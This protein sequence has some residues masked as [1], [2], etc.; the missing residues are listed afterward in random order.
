MLSATLFIWRY[1]ISIHNHY[2]NGSLTWVHNL[3]NIV[4]QRQG[5][6]SISVRM[7]VIVEVIW[8]LFGGNMC[9][10]LHRR[11]CF[12]SAKDIHKT[13]PI[14]STS[15][16]TNVLLLHIRKRYTNLIFKRTVHPQITVVGE[17]TRGWI[18]D[19][20]SCHLTQKQILLGSK[21]HT[22]A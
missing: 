3:G 13:N 19:S 11:I 1:Y 12:S 8:L 17:L 5:Q 21:Q 2:H 9:L 14:L 20:P 16:Q 4:K 6:S 10:K 22:I 15:N 7:S 18:I